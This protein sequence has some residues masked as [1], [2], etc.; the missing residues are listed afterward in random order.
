[1]AIVSTLL[2]STRLASLK[3]QNG[4]SRLS[5]WFTAV[6]KQTYLCI[7]ISEMYVDAVVISDIQIN[8]KLLP[9]S[10]SEGTI[11]ASTVTW[12]SGT[13]FA[14][15]KG[16]WYTKTWGGPRLD[17]RHRRQFVGLLYIPFRLSLTHSHT[18]TRA[19]ARTHTHTHTH[20]RAHTHTH[21]HTEKRSPS[22]DVVLEEIAASV[23][24]RYRSDTPLIHMTTWHQHLLWK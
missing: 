11:C 2:V 22:L 21:T 14:I 1:M 7:V 23:P 12:G 20:A 17:K 5:K 13:L 24:I 10:Q 18:H 3:E 8:L 19:R 6:N 4:T 9:N 16:V 15:K